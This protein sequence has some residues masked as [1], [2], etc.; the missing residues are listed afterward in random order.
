M[1]DITRRE[2]VKTA[3]LGLV[4]VN[5]FGL[6]SDE[7]AFAAGNTTADLV[8]Y[9][10]IFTSENNKIVDAFAVKDGK[11][12]YV[13]D[14]KGAEPFIKKGKTEI[15][16]YTGK[17]LVMPSCGNGHAHY[18]SAY[19]VQSIGTM[20]AYEDTVDKFLNEIVPNTVKKARETGAKVVYGMGWE[21]QNFKNNMPTRHDL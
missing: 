8:V 19:A 21:Y 4:A 7:T 18:L 6:L 10:K 11:F 17:G 5:T 16:D 3:A 14:K 12:I 2:F 13:G 1:K 15:I 20:I 9:G